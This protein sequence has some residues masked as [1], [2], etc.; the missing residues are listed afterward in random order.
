MEFDQGFEKKPEVDAIKF[1]LA[2]LAI[3]LFILVASGWALAAPILLIA[4]LL[5]SAAFRNLYYAKISSRLVQVG[6]LVITL[7]FIVYAEI[8]RHSDYPT[9][10]MAY[11]QYRVLIYLLVLAFVM[12]GVVALN[13]LWLAPVGRHLHRLTAK[14]LKF[15]SRRPEPSAPIIS[16]EALTS[17]SHADELAKWSGLRDKGVLS[18]EEF[19]RIKTKLLGG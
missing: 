7:G 9:I 4:G 8:D 18:E 6:A 16:R 5:A 2:C 17:Y 14:T 15:I 10:D 12:L 3:S 11:P 19:T 13:Y 1:A